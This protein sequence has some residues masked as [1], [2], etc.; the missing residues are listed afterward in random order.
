[1][2]RSN[3]RATKYIVTGWYTTPIWQGN[4]EDRVN[5]GTSQLVR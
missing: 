5:D 2:K 3:Y 4:S 1:M